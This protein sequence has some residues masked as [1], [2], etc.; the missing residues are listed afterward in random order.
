MEA[1]EN[2]LKFI[3]AR[4]D[5]I[6]SLRNPDAP[7]AVWPH[8][9][10]QY[11]KERKTRDTTKIPDAEPRTSIDDEENPVEDGVEDVDAKKY[12]IS[13]LHLIN[14]SAKFRTELTGTWSET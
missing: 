4:G 7:F 11:R 10:R 12:R 3:D 9:Q 14:V 8:Q 2:S 5:G 13:I 1:L 6:I